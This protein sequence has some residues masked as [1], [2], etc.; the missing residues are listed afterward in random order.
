[1]VLQGRVGVV[2]CVSLPPS[3]P[4][5]H[6]LFVPRLLLLPLLGI[7]PT[8]QP[9]STCEGADRELGPA[10]SARAR[11]G[12]AQVLQ[13]T[14]GRVSGRRMVCAVPYSTA[15]C[16]CST[17]TAHSALL[18]AGA[19]GRG[20]VCIVCITVLWR[21]LCPVPLPRSASR[22]KFLTKRVNGKDPAPAFD[23]S[24]GLCL[25]VMSVSV[26]TVWRSGG[27]LSRV[28]WKAYGAESASGHPPSAFC[29][30]QGFSLQYRSIC[31]SVSV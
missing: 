23:I 5:L 27:R 4:F 18:R 29:Q 14:G 13:V 7:A 17:A 11:A 26:W 1:M 8:P 10:S 21:W 20:Y 3:V 9:H 16:H 25:H 24:M 15:Q 31:V 30:L 19:A 12:A 28:F 6:A 22:T 2:A